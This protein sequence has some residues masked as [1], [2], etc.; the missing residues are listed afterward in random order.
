MYGEEEFVAPSRGHA[1][2]SFFKDWGIALLLTA[3]GFFLLSY[4][5]TP[6]LPNQAPDWS[7]KNLDG[8][9]VSLEDFRGQTVV[10]NFWA[11]WCGPCKTE[12][13]TFSQF[14]QDNP[15]IPVLGISVDG[16]AKTLKRASKALGISYPVLI[17][18]R[19]IKEKYKV[20]SLPTT[21]VVGPKGQIKDVHVG[22]MFSPQLKWATQ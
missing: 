12:I 16:N 1:L 19:E 11:T 13:P 22:I 7:L 17:A 4:A 2:W 14:A 15:D 21:V 20:S 10:L 5:R 9:V 3:L 8:D 6:D 18:D